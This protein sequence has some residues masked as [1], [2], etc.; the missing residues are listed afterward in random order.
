M[1]ITHLFHSGFLIELDRTALLFDWYPPSEGR[2]TADIAHL[3]SER[4]EKLYVFVSHLHHDH[5]TPAVWDLGET[6]ELSG[7]EI[8]YIVDAAVAE[9][10]PA[11]RALNVV[12]CAPER[13]YSIDGRLSASTLDSTDEGIAFCVACDGRTIYHAGDLSVWWWPERDEALNRRSEQRCRRFL[14]PLEGTHIDIAMLPITPRAGSDGDRGIELF[15]Q[16]IGA[17]TVVPM[18]YRDDRAGALALA[19][20]ARLAPWRSRI[21]F[22]ECFEL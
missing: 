19:N 14:R 12:A 17:D 4:A 7:T 2:R 13:T 18:H 3:G 11:G 1:R 10:A 8:V 20:S 6:E 5:Y 16:M 15:M 9:R 22:D 21:R